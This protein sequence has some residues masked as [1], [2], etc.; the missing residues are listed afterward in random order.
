MAYEIILGRDIPDREQFG[1]RG[2]IL[3]GKHYVRMGQVETL[4]QP[5]YLD[6]HK[7]HVIFIAGKRGSGKSYALGVIAEGIQMLDDEEIRKRLSV[8]IFDTMGIYWT[9]KYPNHR[10]EPLFKDWGLE[11]KSIPIEIH[12]PFAFFKDWKEKGIPTDHPFA[13]NAGELNPEDWNIAFELSF[14][15]PVAVFIERVILTLLEQK[16]KEFSIDDI[17]ALVRADTKEERTVRNAAENRFLSAKRWGV[18]SPN[19]TK[20]RDL[21]KPATVSV[22]D[23]SPYVTMPNGWRIKQLVLGI[24][25]QKLFVERM[26]TRRYE[27]FTA[28]ESAAHYLLE[29]EKKV[30]EEMPLVWLL[31][32]EAHEFLPKDAR[33]GSTDALITLLRE[34]RQPGIAMVMATQQ[35]GKIHTDA[36]TQSDIILAHRLTAKIDTDALGALVQTYLRAGIDKELENL[37]R[38]PG[39]CLA[40]DDVNERIY[41]MRIRPRVSWHGGSAPGAVQVKK[42]IFEF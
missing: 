42:K 39:T 1:L 24:V 11:G 10:D 25:A 9:M 33:V 23:L 13:I 21:A 40:M 2:T 27:E 32:D 26:I 15:D 35:P 20:I 5:V 6:L 14:T 22:I 17:L 38:V 19:A 31:I 36:M 18:F 16:G 3:L 4:S 41:P 37:P 29:E 12:T 7:A 34:G 28:V 8:I 30:G